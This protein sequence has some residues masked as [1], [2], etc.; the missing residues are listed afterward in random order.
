M[1]SDKKGSSNEFSDLFELT[2][3]FDPLK[4]LL[5]RITDKQN[6]MDVELKLLKNEMKEKASAKEM[7][8]TNL[9]VAR[10]FNNTDNTIK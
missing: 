6:E 4:S 9:R 10:V 1:A 7:N 2:W 3:S 8:D 5:K